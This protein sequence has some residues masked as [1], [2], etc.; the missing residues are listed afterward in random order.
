MNSLNSRR[1]RKLS[2]RIPHYGALI[3]IGILSL[4]P[5]YFMAVTG[6]KNGVQ[7]QKNPFNIA[8]AHP[9]GNFYATAWSYLASPF[10]HTAIVI[11]PS[12]IGI[13][14]LGMLSGYAFARM[15]FF[16]STFLFYAIF[17]LL[18]IPGFLTLI[19][20]FLEVRGMGLV[21]NPLGLILPYI[22]GGQAFAI[23]VFR[24]AINDI[25]E[26]LFEAARIDGA[27]HLR[28]LWSITLVFCRP[29]M[30]AVG[31]LN[32]TTFWGDY[33]FPSLVLNT[34]QSTAAMAIGNFQPPPS[35]SSVNVVNMQFAAYTIVS[36]P[37]ILLFIIFLRY[38]ISGM[39]SGAVK[40]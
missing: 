30:V 37:L 39:A 13:L 8:I 1:V 18:L 2:V 10:V 4:F 40:M 23:F 24:S 33:V 25:P 26:E 17:G 29:I 12:I 20:L 34:S 11:V 22:A 19:P 35:V 9:F 21:N 36:V 6:L 5:I 3:V 32:I 38:F 14:A 27:S 31:L 16:G 7:L 28:M 15:E